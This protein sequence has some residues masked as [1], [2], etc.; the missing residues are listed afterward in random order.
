MPKQKQAWIWKWSAIMAIA[1][2]LQV[3][4]ALVGAVLP[5]SWSRSVRADLAED[6]ITINPLVLESHFFILLGCIQTVMF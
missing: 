4:V 5:Q 1:L 2:I 3:G 6:W